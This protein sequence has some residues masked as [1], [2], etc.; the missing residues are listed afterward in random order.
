MYKI[1]ESE[2][3]VMSAKY[4]EWKSDVGLTVFQR[5]VWRRRA[6]FKGH[7]IRYASFFNPKSKKS[8]S[9]HISLSWRGL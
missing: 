6:N 1:D 2:S 4:G 3:N 8:S 5:N 7:E 9:L